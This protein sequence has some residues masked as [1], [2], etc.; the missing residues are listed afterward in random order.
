MCIAQCCQFNRLLRKS[1]S[2]RGL[3]VRD[4]GK[5]DS[6]IYNE[7]DQLIGLEGN[8]RTG[9]NI[10]ANVFYVLSEEGECNCAPLSNKDSATYGTLLQT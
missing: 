8:R 5:G 2:I 6:I 7:E 4:A 9:D 10:I 3:I 1:I